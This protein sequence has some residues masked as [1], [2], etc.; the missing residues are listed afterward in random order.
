MDKNQVIEGYRDVATDLV[1][2]L[3]TD[4]PAVAQDILRCLEEAHETERKRPESSR[5]Q[6]RLVLS[7]HLIRALKA[8]A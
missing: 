7:E 6:G 8:G 3:T 4:H 1:I 2:W 5:R